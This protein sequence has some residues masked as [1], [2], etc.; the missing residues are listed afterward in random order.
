M[1][2]VTLVLISFVF[3]TLVS[4]LSANEKEQ[5]RKETRAEVLKKVLELQTKNDSGVIVK[6][7]QGLGDSKVIAQTCFD[8]IMDLYNQ[9]SIDTMILVGKTGID[10][11][12]AQAE[13]IKEKE[14]I[15]SQRLRRIAQMMAFN[16]AA[17]TWPGWGEQGITLNSE[18]QKFGLEMALLDYKMAT[19]MDYPPDKIANSLWIIGAH[20][21]AKAEYA[22]ARS[23]FEQAKTKAEKAG[24]PDFVLMLEGYRNMT[25]VLSGS[26]TARSELS[27]TVNALRQSQGE[28]ALFFA[29]Q[30]ETALTIF[31]KESQK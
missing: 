16:L 7:I 22:E 27:R 23:M 3:S 10:L 29:D 18:H 28:D 26:E 19:D 1:K 13:R 31:Q 8:L 6:Y 21:L 4:Q 30:L 2:Y 15:Q 25:D 20:Y 5:A 12:L 9:K 14:P 11:C 17:N 24:Q